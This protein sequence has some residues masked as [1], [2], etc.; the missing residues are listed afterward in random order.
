MSDNKI[1]MTLGELVDADPALGKLGRIKT[2]DLPAPNAVKTEYHLRRLLKKV[3]SELKHYSEAQKEWF[4]ELGAERT[5]TAFEEQRTG[6][7]K[8]MEILPQN[9]VLFRQ[10]EKEQR[11]IVVT[12][13]WNPLDPA[14]IRGVG[15]L[16]V[17][18]LVLLGPLVQGGTP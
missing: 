18:D 2:K 14:D 9:Q 5:S 3:K 10:R 8:I 16:T 12:I 13:D 11:A 17:E 4:E 1:T 15:E 7:R 6:L